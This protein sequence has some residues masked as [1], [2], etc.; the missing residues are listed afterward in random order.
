MYSAQ[1]LSSIFHFLVYFYRSQLPCVPV[2]FGCFF[3]PRA[4]VL[5]YLGMGQAAR[6]KLVRDASARRIAGDAA[7]GARRGVG[8]GPLG[9]PLGL[10][11]QRSP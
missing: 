4:G 9:Y 1:V 8:K 6:E 3:G 2:F 7:A 5:A 11:G 10:P